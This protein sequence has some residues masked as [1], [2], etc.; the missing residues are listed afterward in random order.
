MTKNTKIW[1][2][3]ATS[4]IL[5]GVLLFVI[6]MTLNDWDFKKLT[7][8]GFE[9][10]VYDIDEV[11][12]DIRIIGDT[13]DVIILP[14]EDG[15]CRV[16]CDETDNLKHSVEVENGVL[17]INFTDNRRWFEN[18]MTFGGSTRATVYLPASELG[19][20]SIEL[21]TGDISA[22]GFRANSI[23]FQVSTGDIIISEAVCRGEIK[24]GVSTGDTEMNNVKCKSLISDGNT[25]DVDLEK[26]IA[27]ECF[28]I[29]RST[30]DVEFE[31]CDARE[32]YIETDTGDVE[33]TFLSQKV[34]I[35]NTSTG[36]VNVPESLTG[37]KCKITTS[38]GDVE[39]RID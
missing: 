14:S 6:V 33:G 30:G 34:F 22:E 21:S 12:E 37:G 9:T 11:F 13:T 29:E 4:L 5:I 28:S 27:E 8:A 7:R 23:D 26:V 35:V 24:I 20:I 25:G 17:T 16:I 3:V 31:K 1:L 19:T 15:K 2:I 10:R 18:V 32:I 39:I 38:T 36:D